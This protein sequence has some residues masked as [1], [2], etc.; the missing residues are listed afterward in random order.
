[1][2]E[3][4]ASG[5]SGR[6]AQW[7]RDQYGSSQWTKRKGAAIVRLSDGTPDYFISVTLSPA[8]ARAVSSMKD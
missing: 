6:A 1:V 4:I 3:R 2:G 8:V 7:L 5:S